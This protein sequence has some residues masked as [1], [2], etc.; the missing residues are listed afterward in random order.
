MNYTGEYTGPYWSDGQVQESVEWG[1]KTPQSE[2]DWLSRQ[3][4]SAYAHYKDGKHR[5]AADLIYMREAKKLAGRFP[6]IA[7]SL[8]GYG[9]YTGRQ[10]GQ[11]ASDVAMSTKLTGS[12]LLG[13]LK[14]GAGGIVDSYKRINGTYLKNELADVQ[15]YYGTDPLKMSKPLSIHE[16]NEKLVER[17][18]GRGGSDMALVVNDG[19]RN[20]TTVLGRPRLP[21]GE[22]L[23]VASLNAPASNEQAQ[24]QCP[25]AV[26]HTSAFQR[27]RKKFR[28][29]KK[30]RVESIEERVQR[31]SLAQA[32]K[33]DKHTQLRKQALASK[34]KK[35]VTSIKVKTR[36][37]YTK[38]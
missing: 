3:H 28:K 19:Q 37:G 1:S 38:I 13:V 8:V 32:Q 23:V 9:N 18:S 36:E 33:F 2:L 22:R 35:N 31:L 7:G 20:D 14:Y 6:E 30:N 17:G 12:P 27:L 34:P 10:L 26:T 5:E 24:A 16:P 21:K 4:D 29:K 25:I 11:L 15:K